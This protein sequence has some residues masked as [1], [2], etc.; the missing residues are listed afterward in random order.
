MRK[1]QRWGSRLLLASVLIVLVVTLTPGNGKILGN[2]LDKV[3]HFSIFLFL[4]LSINFKFRNQEK[5]IEYLLWAVL[6][7]LLTEII[8]QFI[9]GRNMDLYDVL[10]NLLGVIF[11][12]YFS[13]KYQSLMNIILFNSEA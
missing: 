11:G 5:Q 2:Y 13:G 9:P 4:S 8:Q 10:A 3:A 7:G 6:L 12:Y 1:Y